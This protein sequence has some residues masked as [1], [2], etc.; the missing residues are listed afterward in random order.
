[1]PRC[2]A[3]PSSGV[4][5]INAR[6]GGVEALREQRPIA[7][8]SLSHLRASVLIGMTSSARKSRALLVFAGF[9]SLQTQK[10]K[11]ENC[12]SNSG[13]GKLRWYAFCLPLTR[14]VLISYWWKDNSTHNSVFRAWAGK[15]SSYTCLVRRADPG[16][17]V[18]GWEG[19]RALQTPLDCGGGR[20]RGRGSGEGDEQRGI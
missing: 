17:S 1:M 10:S 18:P 8:P 19:G 9:D 13:R 16:S 3:Y 11:F 12:I 5:R 6:R 14:E 15:S 2:S 7:R 4:I 20:K